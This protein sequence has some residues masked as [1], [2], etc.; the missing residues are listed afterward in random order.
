MVTM[1]R[2]RIGLSVPDT[3]PA[4]AFLA[5]SPDQPNYPARVQAFVHATVPDTWNGLRVGFLPTYTDQGGPAVWGLPTSQPAGDPNN[6]HFV[7]QRF[8]NGILL[9]DAAAGTSTELGAYV[10]LRAASDQVS[11]REAWV[12]WVDDEGYRGL[13]AG[14]F[15]L[16]AENRAPTRTRRM[17]GR[18]P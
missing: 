12:N 7:Y 8:Q 16:L 15:E 18:G 14:P 3:D 5:P 13:N 10:R 9:F 11:A 1:S 4:T 6:P 2:A 17:E